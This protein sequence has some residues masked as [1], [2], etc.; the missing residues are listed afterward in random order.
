MS[1]RLE[2][3]VVSESVSLDMITKRESIFHVTHG[4]YVMEVPTLIPVLTAS[5][6]WIDDDSRNNRPKQKAEVHVVSPGGDPVNKFEKVLDGTRRYEHSLFGIGK[7]PIPEA[8]DLVFKIL[9]DGEEIDT[10]TIEVQVY[11]LDDVDT[12][13]AGENPAS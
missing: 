2:Y 8:G 1:R 4:I 3:F 12:L 9:L 10:H 11:N 13:E 7:I 6:V 5:A